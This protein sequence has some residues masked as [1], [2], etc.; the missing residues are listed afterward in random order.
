MSSSIK[1]VEI[2]APEAEW[3][4]IRD[5]ARFIELMRLARVANSLGVTYPPLAHTLQ[6]QSPAARRDRFAAFLYAAALL[7]EGLD[8]AQSLGPWFRDRDQYKAGF[9]AIFS[10]P[11]F[12]T[13]YA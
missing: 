7:T 9:A 1:D 12:Q 4:R 10:D 2:V 3:P 11:S 5:D 6:D 8:T 13:L